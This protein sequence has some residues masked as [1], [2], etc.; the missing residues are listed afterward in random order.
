[1]PTADDANSRSREPHSD[2]DSRFKGPAKPGQASKPSKSSKS[3]KS[4]KPNRPPQN[5]KPSRPPKA[6]AAVPSAPGTIEDEMGVPIP[7]VI[8]APEAWVATAIKRLPEQ[9]TLD[10]PQIFGR[11][12]PIAIDIGCG[13]GRFVLSSA[14]RRPDWDHVAID[15][16]PLVIRYATRRANQRGLSNTRFA[17]CDGSRFLSQFCS[18]ASIDE[19]HIYHP[20]PYADSERQH[21]RMLTPEFMALVHRALRPH[22]K[23]FLQTD[24]PAY[25]EYFKQLVAATMQWHDQAEPWPEDPHGRSR[26]EIMATEQGLTIYR[27][28]A[29]RRDDLDEEAMQSLV[30]NL[31]QPTFIAARSDGNEKR[32]RNW[33]GGR[34]RNK[35]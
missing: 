1:M 30:E 20:Q 24:N 21:R 35:R 33:R 3:S 4:S 14:V 12:A 10:F 17:A 22:G 11:A 7:G 23:L 28:W 32:S 2:S 19:I 31:P 27:G 6:P 8:L 25:W 9:G 15:I 18:P 29:E 5:A 13:N 16:L 26:R 34:R